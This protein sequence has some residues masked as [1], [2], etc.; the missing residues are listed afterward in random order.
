VS[1]SVTASELNE[2][3]TRHSR[4]SVGLRGWLEECWYLCPEYE[5]PPLGRSGLASSV[6]LPSGR[7][8]LPMERSKGLR[9]LRVPDAT[10]GGLSG[11][12]LEASFTGDLSRK[13]AWNSYSVRESDT[14]VP[15][16]SAVEKC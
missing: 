10:I 8:S 16:E 4:P 2:R 7:L 5:A 11:R 3:V 6:R 13:V 15:R 14:L 12:V 1:V 9:P